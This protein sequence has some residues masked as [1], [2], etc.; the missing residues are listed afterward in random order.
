MRFRGRG[1][2]R[3]S[4]VPM[5]SPDALIQLGA[6]EL[7]Q[8]CDH[9]SHMRYEPSIACRTRRPLCSLLPQFLRSTAFPLINFRLCAIICVYIT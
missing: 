2:A 3:K 8:E 5:G 7:I 1:G 4:Y 6:V 9:S